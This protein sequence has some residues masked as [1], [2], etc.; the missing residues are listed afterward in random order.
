MRK[1]RLAFF[2]GSMLS[3]S[4]ALPLS[5]QITFSPN[6][7]VFDPSSTNAQTGA[8]P[9]LALDANN[10]VFV[11]VPN[12]R[13]RLWRSLNGGSTWTFLGPVDADLVGSGGDS[14]VEFDGANR[15]YVVD[16]VIQ[17]AFSSALSRYTNPETIT[18]STQRDFR[19]L[20]TTPDEDR[21]WLATFG[22]D[23]AYL[24]FHDLVTENVFVQRSFDGGMTFLPPVPVITDPLLLA[25]TIPNTNEGHVLTDANTGA[26]YSMFSASTPQD[27]I[28][29]PP[30]GPLRRAILAR[31]FDNGLTWDDVIVY[32][33]KPGTSLGNLFP[34][35]AIDRAGNLYS[36][37][38]ANLDSNLQ[39][40]P[41]GTLN[42]FYTASTDQG[43]HWTTPVQ[44]NADVGSHV[45]PWVTAGCAGAVDIVWYGTNTVGNPNTVPT[46]T[47][48]WNVFLAQTL[49]G[50]RVA[51]SFQQ[52][53][54]SDHII[55]EG[56]ISTGGTFG[57]SDRSLLDFFQVA[58][59]TNGFANVV[60][61]DTGIGTGPA[62]V[63]F[64][65]QTGGTGILNCTV[66]Q[67]KVDITGGGY[68][69]VDSNSDKGEFG[70]NASS[71]GAA[72]GH[73]TYVDHSSSGFTFKATTVQSVNKSG[74]TATITGTGLIDNAMQT[75]FTVKVV[76]NGEPGTNDFF[77]I[78]LTATGYSR[79]GN[80]AAG[81]IVIH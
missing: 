42:I 9:S 41:T 55:H 13:V 11:T 57:S 79:S 47:T 61:A 16:L 59:D 80:L 69:L 46:T 60:W 63:F 14:D 70:L 29:N 38:A 21:Q 54:V 24:G 2:F 31:S 45:M 33:G 4:L 77:G 1:L 12:G 10:A 22:S 26:V 7:R 50:L 23:T 34:G 43:A 8:E 18:S 48:D 53:Q 5:A 40:T 73:V 25:E 19:T 68:I 37:F 67:G 76:D 49:N 28:S 78:T 66:A 15:L 30:F 65:R 74:N 35:F 17:T 75:T 64:A 56:Q 52:A 58:H 62:Q 44:V 3:V 71:T 39:L 36:V 27:N 20:I 6:A 72:A 51:P 32:D 81:N